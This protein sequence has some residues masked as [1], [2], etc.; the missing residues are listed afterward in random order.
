MR[1][2]NA[3]Y[4]RMT[5]IAATALALG[6]VANADIVYSDFTDT[7]QEGGS[8]SFEI[9]GLD[10]EFG[11]QTGGPLNYAYVTTTSEGAGIF[12]PLLNE[13]NARNFAAGDNIGTL[14]SVLNMFPLG[15]ADENINLVMYDYATGDGDFAPETTG[16]VGFGFGSGVQF[17]YGWIEFTLY[18]EGEF[19]FIDINGWAY[20]DVVNESIT[21]GQIPAPGAFALLALGGLAGRRRRQ[22]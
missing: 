8:V 7:A 13:G 6:S 18:A 1:K 21:V 16:Y 15:G 10:Y 2:E 22:G 20:N 12:V 5:C 11:I 4:L 9:N 19:E 17:N 14:T 3:M